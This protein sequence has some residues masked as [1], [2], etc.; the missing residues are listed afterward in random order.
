MSGSGSHTPDTLQSR[1]SGCIENLPGS[2]IS[3]CSWLIAGDDILHA[4]AELSVS[5]KAPAFDGA[6]GSHSAN[7]G[8][9]SHQRAADADGVDC[10][11]RAD[12]RRAILEGHGPLRRAA[13][14][15]GDRGLERH[16][17]LIGAGIER[18]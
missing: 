8:S 6:Q 18:A 5:V 17:L 9:P 12:L 1:A 4:I 2:R 11:V 16:I 3:G 15:R 14:I 7:V 10:D 13:A